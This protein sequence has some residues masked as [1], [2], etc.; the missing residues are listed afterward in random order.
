MGA[1]MTASRAKES[2]WQ[3]IAAIP[4]GRVVAY[5]EVARMAGL[6][7]SARHVGRCLRDLPAGS[8]LPWYR[9]VRA[10]RSL[11][12]PSGSQSYLRQRSLLAAEG[13]VFHGE[14]V[15]AETMW[16]GL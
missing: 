11:A 4:V 14:K 9:V 8:T 6:P 16:N 13:V 10:D 12:F 5:G 15:A 2:I 3:V 7:G 1:L